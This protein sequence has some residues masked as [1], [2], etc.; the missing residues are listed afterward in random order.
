DALDRALLL[1]AVDDR[2]DRRVRD[3]A[4]GADPLMELRSGELSIAPEVGHHV[5]LELGQA[6]HLYGCRTDNDEC[7]EAAPVVNR[8]ASRRDRPGLEP[9]DLSARARPIPGARIDRFS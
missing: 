5:E 4:L 3:A 7:S 9:N 2:L 8:D 6:H 1:E